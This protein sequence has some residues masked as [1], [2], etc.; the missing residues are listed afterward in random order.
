MPLAG[1]AEHPGSSPGGLL[2]A[3]ENRFGDGELALLNEWMHIWRHAWLARLRPSPWSPKGMWRRL[4]D[5]RARHRQGRWWQ[6][7]PNQILLGLVVVLCLPVRLTV[8]APAELVPADPA[9]IRAP[10]DG[11]IGQFHVSP[12]DMVEAGQLLFSFDEAAIASRLEVARLALATAETEYRQLAQ[13]A[14]TD[15]RAKGQLAVLVG[16]I[17]EK[18]AE[19]EFL[20]GQFE[21]ARV[22]AP[23]DGA[24]IFDDPSEWIGRP[25]QTGERVMRIARPEEAEIEA[26]IPI[27][28]A[29]P[30]AAD[31]PVDLYLAASP[32]AAVS[33][34]LRYLNHDATPRPDGHYAYR[35]RARLDAAAAQR[36][37]LKGTARLHGSRVPLAYWVLRRPLATIRQFLAL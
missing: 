33:G 2:L 22:L 4:R 23:Q 28:D 10:L 13:M 15:P 34:R 9:I 29:I 26:W 8:L 21:R 25:V 14:L 3:G 31:A 11:V 16:R 27:G 17:G 35:A 32:F 30:L 19:A 12:N 36:I 1:S 6:R 7:R 20:A 37:G 5:W 18:R 24:A